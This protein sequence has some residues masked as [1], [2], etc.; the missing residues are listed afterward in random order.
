MLAGMDSYLLERRKVDWLWDCKLRWWGCAGRP[1][2]PPAALQQRSLTL[3]EYRHVTRIERGRRAASI[4]E[5]ASSFSNTMF[6]T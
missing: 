5:L 4:D 1:S 3:C 6:C 2:C